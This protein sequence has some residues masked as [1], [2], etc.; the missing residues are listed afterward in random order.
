MR[1]EG[2]T[3]TIVLFTLVG[4]RER[5][6]RERKLRRETGKDDDLKR[7][8]KMERGVAESLGNVFV[9]LTRWGMNRGGEKRTS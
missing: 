7:P 9:Q 5:R 6:E 2:T 4:T 1:R 8:W 3:N